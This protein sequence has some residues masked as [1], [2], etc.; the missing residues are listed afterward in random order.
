MWVNSPEADR[1]LRQALIDE[2]QAQPTARQDC[3]TA[4]PIDRLSEQQHYSVT[5]QWEYYAGPNLW[6]P[7][8]EVFDETRG[9][10]LSG[11]VRFTVPTQP[12]HAQGAITAKPDLYFIRCRLVN[13]YYERPP[14]I[15]H[16]ALNAVP[17]RHVVDVDLTTPEVL[18]TSNGHAAQSFALKQAPVVPRSTQ[19]Q[20]EGDPEAWSEIS[21]WDRVGPALL[22]RTGAGP[23]NR[24][25]Y[26]WRWPSRPGAACQS[27]ISASQQYEISVT[28]YQ[29]G[30]GADVS[31]GT[32]S[33]CLGNDTVS[34]EQPFAA[35][36][37][38][39]R[40]VGRCQRPG[41]RLA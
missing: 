23:R 3:R 8:A 39:M 13:G 19:L 30:G 22:S 5:T 26:F 18:G 41:H 40:I 27:H 15:Q 38:P 16:I 11:A 29:V 34:V 33:K 2:D 1:Q 17:A 12:A 6:T 24:R 9:L 31:A 37:A 28:H 14:Q 32:L 35:V 4:P 7:L 10:T 21:N 36:G 20:V 25:D